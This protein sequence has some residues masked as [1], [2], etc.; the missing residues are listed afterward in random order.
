MFFFFVCFF[1][2]FSIRQ[3]PFFLS[4]FVGLSIFSLLYRT[5]LFL[6]SLFERPPLP[7]SSLSLFL[8]TFYA[9]PFFLLTSLSLVFNLFSPL[10]TSYVSLPSQLMLLSSLPFRPKL[11]YLSVFFPSLPSYSHPTQHHFSVP[12]PG[13]SKP[14]SVPL[15]IPF[16]THFHTSPSVSPFSPYC[17][18]SSN[19]PIS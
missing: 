15:F 13:C 18:P 2:P 5:F 1:F 17:F 7:S 4:L 16:S 11:L 6:P 19:T 8:F 14:S 9:S 12:P 3:F 10:L